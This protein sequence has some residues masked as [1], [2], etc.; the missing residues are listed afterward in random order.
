M[1]SQTITERMQVFMKKWLDFPTL[2]P[3]LA[4]ILVGAV[5]FYLGDASDA[6]GLSL[7]G[8]TAAFLLIMW[9]VH[10]TGVIEE[11]FLAPILWFCFGAGGILLSIVLLLDGEF[12]ESPGLA[13]IGIA[14]GVVFIVIGALKLRK[15][16]GRN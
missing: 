12:E 3:I 10:N 15:T 13:L 5:L 14:L 7:L 6:P 16:R 9:G 2:L 11:G 4:G 8:L 1:L